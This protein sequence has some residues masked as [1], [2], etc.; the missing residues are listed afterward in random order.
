MGSTAI[1]QIST[2]KAPVVAVSY[3]CQQVVLSSKFHQNSVFIIFLS[4]CT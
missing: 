3:M 4:H 1:Q 2:E